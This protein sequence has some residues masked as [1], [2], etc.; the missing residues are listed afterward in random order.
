[1]IV[2]QKVVGISLTISSMFSR[3]ALGCVAEQMSL[4]GRAHSVLGLADRLANQ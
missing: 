2:T 3:C 4:L 1:V